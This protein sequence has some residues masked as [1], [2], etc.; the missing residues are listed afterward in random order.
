MEEEKEYTRRC[1]K[2]NGA[3]AYQWS[4]SIP[5]IS[6]ETITE[7]NDRGHVLDTEI[8]EQRDGSGTTEYS[9]RCGASYYY[10]EWVSLEI[11]EVAE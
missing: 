5:L 3:G 2:C 7:I 10:R 1:K 4:M 9:C 11:V 8:V 6:V